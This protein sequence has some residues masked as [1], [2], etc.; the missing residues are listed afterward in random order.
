MNSSNKAA[1]DY[2]ARV[3]A[4]RIRRFLED[5]ANADGSDSALRRFRHQWDKF[6]AFEMPLWIEWMK[7]DHDDASHEE[8]EEAFW[9]TTFFALQEGIREV[10]ESPDA[11]TAQWRV[12]NLQRRIHDHVPP[13]NGRD[14]NLYPPRPTAP[15]QA[16]TYLRNSVDVLRKCS[17]P[18]CGA[19]YF[20]ATRRNQLY[21][22]EACSRPAQRAA[23]KRWW[24][25]NGDKWRSQR[26]AR[27]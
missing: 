27:A 14:P 8:I 20:F 5:L 6:F 7:Q 15:Q 23:K 16:L 1:G 11:N 21:C 13:S 9:N 24:A 4:R 25:E 2:L 19:P 22:S 10:W 26:K 17:N 12:F 18:E 3:P